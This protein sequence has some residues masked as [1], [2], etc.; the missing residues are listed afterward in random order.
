MPF[1]WY[2]N[3]SNKTV[4][5]APWGRKHKGECV[6]IIRRL[7]AVLIVFACLFAFIPLETRAYG[8][9]TAF[10][11]IVVLDCSGSMKYS[12][13]DKLTPEGA[14][15]LLDNL[16]RQTSNERS[17]YGAVFFDGDIRE[18]IP[19]THI[20]TDGFVNDIKN[21]MAGYN[22][23]G[24][25]TDIS[26]ALGRALRLFTEGGDAG[27]REQVIILLTDGDDDPNRSMEELV[28]E[29]ESVIREAAEKDIRIFTIGLNHNGNTMNPAVITD[30]ANNTNGVMY[31]VTS[32]DGLQAVFG[33]IFALLLDSIPDDPDVIVIPPGG[34]ID[35]EVAI[36]DEYVISAFIN[37]IS[38]KKISVA[39]IDPGNTDVT[40][41]APQVEIDSS[42][43]Y[44]SI[45][46]QAP[47][48]GKWIVRITGEPNT[49]IES[50]L[51]YDYALKLNMSINGSTDPVVTAPAGG[52]SAELWLEDA[53]G[54]VTDT[55]IYNA[56]S[57][58]VVTL[59]SGGHD[60]PLSAERKAGGDGFAVSLDSL[61]VGIYTADAEL[62]HT[63]F[64]K[65]LP[66]SR[67]LDI[68]ETAISSP[69]AS[70]SPGTPTGTPS[71]TSPSSPSSNP[72]PAPGASSGSGFF[73]NPMSWVIIAAVAVVLIAAVFLLLRKGGKGSKYEPL[74][75]MKFDILNN[76]SNPKAK[77]SEPFS[78]PRKEIKLNEIILLLD[79]DGF[80]GSTVAERNAAAVSICG[81][82]E[83]VIFDLKRG[84]PVVIRGAERHTSSGKPLL[85]NGSASQVTIELADEMQ[86]R[87]MVSF[88]R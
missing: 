29:R 65:L 82:R 87:V 30:I 73:D 52:V 57:S 24:A 15:M 27:G 20:N 39:V 8:G 74:R 45:H 66:D 88:P 84:S 26:R 12:D 51:I 60:I 37:L 1:I 58:V 48:K 59:G 40:N 6:I 16:T 64:V 5:P 19:L 71:G 11:V 83:G 28:A 23:N 44:T 18:T 47:V 85:R 41:K 4:L 80:N 25:K 31:E 61:A 70:V 75:R 13:P 17:R 50:Q 34:S 38:H 21:R 3:Y 49:Q 67:T 81:V 55:D 69:T 32:S 78:P 56:V 77:F 7:T 36:P 62:D 53:N 35:K 33:Q 22:Q 9:A 76:N 68:T 42:T 54:R 46:L 63:H 86:T 79:R 2:I 43:S 72:T 10:D 14:R